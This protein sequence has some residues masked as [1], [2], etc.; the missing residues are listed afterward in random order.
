MFKTAGLILIL[1]AAIPIIGEVLKFVAWILA[2]VGFFN[3]KKSTQMPES[4][5]I[6]SS[7]ENRF[8]K[9]C[10]ASIQT[11]ASFCQ[12]CGKKIE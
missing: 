1:G 11:E 12:K 6:V 8:C 5:S 10:G 3:I 7:S 4:K 2:A 9:Y